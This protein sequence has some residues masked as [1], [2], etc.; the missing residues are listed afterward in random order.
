MSSY[1]LGIDGGQSSTTALIG[2]ETG[3]VI[4]Y[5]RGGPC[6]HVGAAEG[7]AKFSSA[8]QSCVSA[9]CEQASLDYSQVRF[10]SGCFG[11]SGGPA[12]KEHILREM[13]RCDRMLVA[14]DGL[15]ALAGATG[16]RPG[17]IVIAGTGSIAFGRNSDAKTARAGGWGYVFGDEGAGFDIVRQALRAA[18]RAEEGWGPPTGLREVLLEK[19]PAGSVNEILHRFYTVE[20]PRSRVAAMANIVDETANRGDR[21]ASQILEK[22]AQELAM[23]AA[24]VRHQI[25]VK[26]EPVSVG[27]IGGVFRSARLLTRFRTLVELE[28]G[29]TVGP[30]LYGPGAGALIEAYRNAGVNVTISD[31]PEVEKQ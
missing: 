12:D 24:A 8:I 9:A 15:I 27:Y 1:F 31:V 29:N 23:L 11:L 5:G 14:H 25:F 19:V 30:P 16:G 10:Q 20:Y 22:A 26:G 17:V 2:D 6:N 28:P 7:R 3:R 18:L 21:M 13:L 4:G